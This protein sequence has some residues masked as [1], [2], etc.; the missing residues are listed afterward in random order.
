MSKYL[1]AAW[2]TFLKIQDMRAKAVLAR[3]HFWY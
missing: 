2:E 1:K 3:G